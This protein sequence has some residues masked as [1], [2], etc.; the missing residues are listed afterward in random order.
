MDKIKALWYA[1]FIVFIIVLANFLLNFFNR[2]EIT[3]AKDDINIAKEKINNAIVKIDS[4]QSHI[5]SLIDSIDAVRHNIDRLNMNVN[6][7]NA[8]M[9]LKIS[10]TSVKMRALLDSV[11]ADQLKLHTLKKELK[12]LK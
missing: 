7:L 1:L 9:Q 5:Y 11:K 8:D 3:K 10:K 4:A 2:S 6:M 12:N